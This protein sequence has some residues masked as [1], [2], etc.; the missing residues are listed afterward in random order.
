MAKT[1]RFD[2][3]DT[4]VPQGDLLVFNNDHFKSEIEK[5]YEEQ[6]KAM[7]M[8]L[9]DDEDQNSSSKG[10]QPKTPTK[11]SVHEKSE[12]EEEKEND[13]ISYL[14]NSGSKEKSMGF[15]RFNIKEDGLQNGFKK[16]E[17]ETRI[18]V[19]GE[20]RVFSL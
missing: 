20:T 15:D 6:D 14:S 18:P 5:A 17:P 10:S 12:D 13:V 1:E 16:E 7:N 9:F 4:R 11:F 19:E 8:M 2:N 3:R